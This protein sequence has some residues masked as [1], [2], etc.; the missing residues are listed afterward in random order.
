MQVD[1]ILEPDLTPTQ[2]AELGRKAESYGIRAVWS[3]N[4]FAHW[5]CFMSLVPLAQ[6]TSRILMGPLAVSPFEMHPLKIAN[7]LLSLNELSNG[8]AVIAVGA[9]EGNIDAMRIQ[10]P[11]K[12]V[13][14]TREGIE[15]VRMAGRGQ[16]AQGFKGEDF[17]INLPCTYPW[18]KS[19]TQPLVYG[20]AYREQ[21]LRMEAR[22]ADGVFIGCTPPEVMAQAMEQVK[23]G[24]AKR[25]A[26]MGPLHTNTFWAWHLKRNRAEG[27]RESRRELAWRAIKLQKEMLLQ[28]LNEDEANLVRA[29]YEKF[30]AAWFD[31]S[32]NIQG[33]PEA[34]P[35]RLCEYFTSTGGLEDLD[36]EIERFRMFGRAGLTEVALRL[37]DQP[38]EALEIIGEHVLPKLR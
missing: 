18:L 10:R 15:I 20:T 27:Y 36:R 28:C 21:M 8:R 32:G 34:I 25:T 2:V 9:G 4:Y 30:V 23:E 29:N 24:A 38:M 35:N 12:I 13:R 7:S 33:V 31:R 11:E 37:H 22:V 14:A 5:D 17:G 16:L 26:D 19:P 3:S 6:S 1:I